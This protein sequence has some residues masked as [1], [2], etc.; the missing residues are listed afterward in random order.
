MKKEKDAKELH[1]ASKM[2]KSNGVEKHIKDMHKEEKQ[3][4][5]CGCGKNPCM[6]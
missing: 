2:H 1:G 6:T 3:P 5:N 4:K